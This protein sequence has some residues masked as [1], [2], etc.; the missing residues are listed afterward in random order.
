MIGIEMPGLKIYRSEEWYVAEL[1]SLH[2]VTRAKSIRSLRKN[3][4]EAIEV[5]VEGLMELK[6][7]KLNKE[8]EG[9]MLTVSRN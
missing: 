6:V 9:R 3:L 4:K 8:P 5:A 1:P 7:A 2:V